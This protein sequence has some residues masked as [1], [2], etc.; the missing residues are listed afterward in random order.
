MWCKI[1]GFAQW[2]AAQC[3]VKLPLGWT[4]R[5]LLALLP[6]GIVG[7]HAAARLASAPGWPCC[8]ASTRLSMMANQWGGTRAAIIRI[9]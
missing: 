8:R 1:P 5:W 3:G 9:G 4:V 7:H 2:W 6:G